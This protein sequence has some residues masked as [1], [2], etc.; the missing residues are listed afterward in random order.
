MALEWL[1]EAAQFEV[2]DRVG[3]VSVVP[4]E[5]DDWNPALTCQSIH[6]GRWDLPAPG[7]LLGCQQLG[8]RDGAH[9]VLY[10]SLP[11]LDARNP[12]GI[13]TEPHAAG[14]ITAGRVAERGPLAFWMR[15][16]PAQVFRLSTGLK[17]YKQS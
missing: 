7:Q 17:D 14:L 3:P 12:Q 16:H 9:N 10:E 15:H 6:V 11:R 2:V 1:V 13:Q 8:S 4:A 5:L